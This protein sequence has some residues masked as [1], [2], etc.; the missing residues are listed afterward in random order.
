MEHRDNLSPDAVA[1]AARGALRDALAA[2]GPR[3]ALAYLNSRT[4]HRFSAMYRF[5]DATLRNL[6][7]YDAENPDVEQTDD[8]PV[9]ASYCVFVRAKGETFST[10]HA[11]RDERLDAHPKQHVLQAY[12]GVPLRDEEGTMF[13]T[14]CHFDFQ[15]MG[16]ADAEVDL[17]E[18]VASLLRRALGQPWPRASRPE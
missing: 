4:P 6:A 16:I 13:G 18:A 2:G 12:C 10:G 11:A 1:V 15:P 7:F 17:M 3:S 9:M 14:I 8:I 5:D